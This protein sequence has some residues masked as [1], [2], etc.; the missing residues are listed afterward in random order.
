MFASAYRYPVSFQTV[1]AAIM[2]NLGRV[3][4]ARKPDELNW[5]FVGG[6]VATTD[7]SLEHA[8]RR[9]VSEECG[10]IETDEYEY[11]GSY[12]IDDWRYRNEGD[13]IMTAFFK[14]KFIF[15]QVKAQDDIAELIWVGFANLHKTMI[16]PEHHPLLEALQNFK[17]NTI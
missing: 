17:I 8:A 15:G 10:G 1:D 2:D 11:I 4:L 13:K 6:F 3:L 12:R 7:E 16:E 5:R 14:C 9:E